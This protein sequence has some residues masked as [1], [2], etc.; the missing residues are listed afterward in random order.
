MTGID[1]II[2][3]IFCFS[4]LIGYHR[5]FVCSVGDILGIVLGSIIASFAYR[6]PLKL[7]TQFDITGIAVELVFFILTLLFFSL[8]LIILIE[9]LKKRI[10]AKHFID[11]YAGLIIGAFEGF[12][13]TGLLLF[14]M[15]ASFNSATEVQN[16]KLSKNVI[17]FMPAVYEKSEQFGI[18]FPKMILLSTEYVDE[19]KQSKKN[20]QF[21]KLNFS[22]FD[23]Y[24]CMECGGKVKFEGYFQRVGATFIPKFTCLECERT[25]CSCQTYQGFH[26]LYNKCPIEIAKTKLRFDCGHW[27]N[28][29]LITPKGPCPIDNQTIEFWLWEPPQEY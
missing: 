16:S 10:D 12:I 18:I 8:L 24:T 11:R 20:I 2:I 19:F 6:A 7:M 21:S 9:S 4:V 13:F 15:S 17:R 22:S 29:K 23:G 27:S 26:N 1:I 14:I 28:H 25:S 5:G 3:L